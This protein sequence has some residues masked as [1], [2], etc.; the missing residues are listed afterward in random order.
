MAALTTDDVLALE[1][2]RV[3]PDVPQLFE[4][5][6][7]FWSSIGVRTDVEWISQRDCRVPLLMRPGGKF[8]SYD[9][10]GGDMGRGSGS[11]YDKA[12]INVAN[13]KGAIE[14]NYSV[15]LGTD[16]KRKAVLNA[17]RKELADG[18][19]EF[20][21]HIESWCMTDGDGVIGTVDSV[22]L[23]GGPNGGDLM[24]MTDSFGSKLIRPN[25]DVNI[26]NAALT[27]DRTTGAERT[28]TFLD[29]P[30]QQVE[31]SPTL[32]SLIATDK[33]VVSGLSATPPV[34]LLGV[35]YHYD[36]AS[37]GTWLGLSR[38]TNPEIRASRVNAGGAFALPFAR[39]AI[40]KMMDR[41]GMDVPKTGASWWCHPCQAAAYEDFGQSTILINKQDK[42]EGLNM[43]FDPNNLQM[44]GAKLMLSECWDKTRMDFI[45]KSIWGRV[46]QKAPDFYEVDGQTIFPVRGQSG[47]LAAAKL[48]YLVAHFGIFI[49]NTTRATYIDNLTI[50]AGYAV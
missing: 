32:G 24:V 11:R 14:W 33:V 42:E 43:Y 28:V 49:D 48:S 8:G 36:S 35:P 29:I 34:Y 7:R 21:R 39:L 3:R 20:R 38:A 22:T 1:L 13:M 10:A 12:V 23:A 47:G 40:N 15:E 31:I 50:P 17:F 6:D 46:Q 41:A 18:M 30:T 9:P 5:D 2:E 45:V 25:D 27:V 37:T 44:A 16:E 26:Y 4:R 19:D